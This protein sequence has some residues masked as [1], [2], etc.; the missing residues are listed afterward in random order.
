MDLALDNLLWLICHKTPK[1]NFRI[2]Y[3]KK[4]EKG[5]ARYDVISSNDRKL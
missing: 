3:M 1:T 2:I 4:T 5:P